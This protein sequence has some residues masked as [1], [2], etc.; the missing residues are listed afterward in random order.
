M[1]N[2][3]RGVIEDGR[4]LPSPEDKA[5]AMRLNED[6]DRAR[7]GRPALAVEERRFP[8]GSV[9]DG[10]IRAMRLREAER[11]SNG[12]E[13]T[14]EQHSRDDWP[15]AWKW[16]E[17]LFGDCDP[18]TITPEQFIGDP[19][20]PE[21]KGLREIVAMKVSDSEAHRVIKV[22]RALWKK[23]ALRILRAL[24]GSLVSVCQLCA[25]AAQCG[26]ARGRGRA[27]GEARVARWLPGSRCG[28]GC[29][30]GYPALTRGCSKA[31][32]A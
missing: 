6:W 11:R 18:R 1:V 19:Q 23:M 13:W 7:R 3:S 32:G 17:P 28:P 30:L 31:R 10:F 12:I 26:V 27:P 25:T 15:R 4:P 2:L 21:L 9:G 24:T 29:R 8:K 16:I 20:R 5:R 14:K 22:W